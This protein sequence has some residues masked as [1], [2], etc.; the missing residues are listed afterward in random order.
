M[1]TTKFVPVIIG[2]GDVVNR[3]QNAEDSR[4]P[5]ELILQAIRLALDDTGLP[6]SCIR[7]LQSAVDSIDIV[8]TWT[9]PY[10]DL[11]GLIAERLGANP[12][13]KHYSEHGGNQ[14]AK[15]LDE[16]ARRIALGRAKV[17]VVSGGEALAS[18]MNRPNHFS[19]H[20]DRES[21][22]S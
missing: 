15:L 10:P 16:A 6:D 14:P 4:E 11:P 18:C 3:S 19:R 22:R 5:S 13:H 21:Y 7:T 17:A 8:R 1:A 20:W 12:S 9:W 2:G